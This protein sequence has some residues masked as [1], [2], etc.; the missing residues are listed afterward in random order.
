MRIMHK[1][2]LMYACLALMIAILGYLAIQTGKEALRGSIAGSSE[3]LA[4]QILDQI[5]RHLYARI[6]E[7]Q[8][9][10]QDS[11]VQE[12]VAASNRHY[13]DMDDVQ[14]EI[15][16]IDTEWTSV[17]TH[18]TTSFMKSLLNGKLSGELRD[19]ERFPL[20]FDP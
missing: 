18:V 16:R 3:A 14:G 13:A 5:D 6:E 12:S 19:R 2:M 11:L 20:Y 1:L 8:A 7:S 9:Y 10:S 17:P 15:T 4:A